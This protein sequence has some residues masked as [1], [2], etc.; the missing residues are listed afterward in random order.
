MLAV[1][2][3]DLAARDAVRPGPARLQ[4]GIERLGER[5]LLGIDVVLGVALN[6][7]GPIGCGASLGGFF[8][9]GCGATLTSLC[10]SPWFGIDPLR[11]GVLIDAFWV[12][13]PP[14]VLNLRLAQRP[15]HPKRLFPTL[16][17]FFFLVAPGPFEHCEELGNRSRIAFTMS[18]VPVL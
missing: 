17:V 15:H 13:I 6:P 1:G 14:M 8:G 12:S 16:P 7:G 11:P 10:Y 9:Q 3:F 18:R 4:V 2:L 5:A